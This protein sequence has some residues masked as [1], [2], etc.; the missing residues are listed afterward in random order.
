MS[1]SEQ[2]N[3]ALH[4]LDQKAKD[5]VTN[6]GRR[7]AM[8]FA[9]RPTDVIVVTPSNCGTTWM[10]QIMHQLGSGG[11]MS[12]TD[13]DDVVPWIELA[14]DVGQDLNA[15]QKYL[16]IC[17]KTTHGLAALKALNIFLSMEN[18]AQHSTVTLISSKE[19]YFN[20]VR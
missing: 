13:I 9:Q 5:F 6:E 15:E 18:L 4:K 2:L 19:V 1:A 20:L 16:H 10:Q 14:Y 11:D 12:F 7:K 3:Q 17:F 8:S